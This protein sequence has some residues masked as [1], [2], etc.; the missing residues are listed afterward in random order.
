MPKPDKDIIRKLQANIPV[1]I[2]ARILNKILANQIQ[3]PIKRNIQYDKVEFIPEVKKW[4]TIPKSINVIQ[5]ISRMKDKIAWSFQQMQKKSFIKSQH[6]FTIVE[7]NILKTPDKRLIS[8]I[9]KEL[10]KL[11][12]KKKK[13]QKLSRRLE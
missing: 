11:K 3:Q 5:Y 9:Y 6:L 4:F 12:S 2:D 1:N 8:K 10:L 7:E 13:I